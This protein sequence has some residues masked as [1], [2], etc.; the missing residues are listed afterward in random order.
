MPDIPDDHYAAVVDYC[1]QKKGEV[2]LCVCCLGIVALWVVVELQ[3][4]PK[5]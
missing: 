2:M 5:Q 3:V 4:L 1:Q